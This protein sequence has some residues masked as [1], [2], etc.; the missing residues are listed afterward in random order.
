M[1]GPEKKSYLQST[2]PDELE[3]QKLDEA[4][5]TT[6]RL[7]AEMQHLIETSKRAQKEH[8]ELLGKLKEQRAARRKKEK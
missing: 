7:I 1:S 6:K 3:S 5:V 4:V 2:D 8:E